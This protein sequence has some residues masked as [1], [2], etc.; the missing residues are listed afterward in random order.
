MSEDDARSG[1]APHLHGEVEGHELDD[2][3]EAGQRGADAD[4]GEARLGDRGID[5]A[6]GTKLI[7]QALRD[8]VGTL[9]KRMR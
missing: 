1:S 9:G 6:L 5:D 2:G 4:A 3:D 7:E 8:L